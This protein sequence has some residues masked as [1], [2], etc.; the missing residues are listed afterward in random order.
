M[1]KFLSDGSARQSAGLVSLIGRQDQLFPVFS[2]V[3]LL[4]FCFV[5]FFE[6]GFYGISFNLSLLEENKWGTQKLKNNC[7]QK[8]TCTSGISA[9]KT[10][11]KIFF[12]FVF[13]FKF[14]LF[15]SR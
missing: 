14:F 15:L 11:I 9:L 13:L 1:L 4:F 5:E 3:A 6:S 12:S 2:V 10:L 7:W 8:C